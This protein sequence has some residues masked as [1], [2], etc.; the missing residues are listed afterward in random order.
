MNVLEENILE[1]LDEIDQRKIKY[2]IKLLLRQ[3]K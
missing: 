3:S 2:F 1:K